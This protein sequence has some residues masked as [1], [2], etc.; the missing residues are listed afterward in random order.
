MTQEYTPVEW[1]DETPDQLGTT[2]NKARLDQMQTAHHFADGFKEVDTVPTADPGVDYHMV[3]FCTADTTFY[4]WDGTQW[5][6]DVDDSTLALLEAHEADHNNPHVVTKD[7]VGLGNVDNTSDADKP[8]SSATQTALDGKQAT[9]T[10][11][12]TSILS[13]D[14]TPSAALVSDANGKVAASGTSATE[15]GYLSGVTSGIQE[16]I[17]GK[18]PT[19]HASAGTTYGQGDATHYGHVKVDDSMS[20]GSDNPVKNSTIMGFVNSS[21]ATNT[22]DFKGTY[23]AVSDLGLTETATQAQVIAALNAK[24]TWKVGGNPTNNDYCF[25]QFDLSVDPGNIDRYDR[26]KFSGTYGSG[27]SWGYEYT[28]NNSSFTQAQWDTIN[29]LIT[30]TT[31]DPNNP[32]NTPYQGVDVKDIL[33]SMAKTDAVEARVDDIEDGTTVVPSAA[34]ANNAVNA[35]NATYFGSSSA[36]AGSDLKPI[37][38]VNGQ[39]VA[40]TNDFVDT[41]SA[42][43]IGGDKTFTGQI[44]V[45]APALA[46]ALVRNI[47]ISN[48]APTGGSNGDIWIQY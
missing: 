46:S 36:N 30:N 17:N 25:V 44:A 32:S 28:L 27:G 38:I 18:A 15:V 19:S 11:A 43:I 48:Q 2:I 47:T 42:Q 10:G 24:T 35:I 13:A 6:K 21:I 7:Q 4:R 39:A 3:V 14:L 1:V 26:Y 33:A 29:A 34:N 31:T 40:V 5:V 9:V 45:T 41:A 22:A 20:A 8:V 16:Q 37:K 12:A 23:D